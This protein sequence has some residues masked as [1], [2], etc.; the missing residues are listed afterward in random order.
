MLN[1]HILVHVGVVVAGVLRVLLVLLVVVN[2]RRL[3]STARVA[4]ASWVKLR[5][6]IFVLSRG[7]VEY[8]LITDIVRWAMGK[9]A[10]GSSARA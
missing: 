1:R 6:S 7:A 5:R 3:H 2:Q 9:W 8:A 10:A 4:F